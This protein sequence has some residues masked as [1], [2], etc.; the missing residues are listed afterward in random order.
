MPTEKQKRILVVEDDTAMAEIM[1]NKLTTSGFDVAHAENGQKA[2]ELVVSFKPNLVLLDLMLPILDGF[3]VLRFIRTHKDKN[4]KDTP[5][6]ILTN[7]WSKEEIIKAKE[8]NVQDYIIK[9]YLTTEE[10]L[11]KIKLVLAKHGQ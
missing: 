3:G 11:E 7:L 6:V 4:L 2:T 10:I 9:A 1:I 5:V 8:L